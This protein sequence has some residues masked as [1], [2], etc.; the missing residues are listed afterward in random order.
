MS[1]E[2]VVIII[3]IH[4]VQGYEDIDSLVRCCDEVNMQMG[5]ILGLQASLCGC[6]MMV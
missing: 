6:R 3:A 1:G 2:A 4:V 5:N